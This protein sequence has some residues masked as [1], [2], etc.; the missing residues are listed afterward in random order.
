ML[1][2][3]KH[4]ILSAVYSLPLSNKKQVG[5]IELRFDFY[6]LLGSFVQIIAIPSSG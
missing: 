3:L 2:G 4:Q 6:F 1:P 5:T